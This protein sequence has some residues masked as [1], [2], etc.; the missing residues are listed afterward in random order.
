MP[1]MDR[2]ARLPGSAASLLDDGGI[3]VSDETSIT[4]YDRHLARRRTITGVQSAT[5][6][7]D[8]R[9][10][11]HLVALPNPNSDAYHDLA[12]RV[13]DVATGKDTDLREILEAHAERTRAPRTTGRTTRPGVTTRGEQRFAW[14]I[15]IEDR[16]WDWNDEV[17]CEG[18]DRAH[19]GDLLSCFRPDGPIT[20]TSDATIDD[21]HCRV[22]RHVLPLVVCT[23][24]SRIRDLAR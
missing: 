22:G 14:S 20:T 2:C 9:S 24:G 3:A 7:R 18:D 10:I 23:L 16:E 19:E 11:A 15:L 13:R 21:A 6:S 12:P 4:L 17:Y 1:G 8:G 5:A